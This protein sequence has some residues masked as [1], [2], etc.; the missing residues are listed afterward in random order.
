M[1]EAKPPC[2]YGSQ[3]YRKNPDHLNRY[4]HPMALEEDG[5]AD[6]SD[7]ASAVARDPGEHAPLPIRTKRVNKAFVVF[8]FTFPSIIIIINIWYNRG[9]TRITVAVQILTQRKPN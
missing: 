6:D 2:K 4:Y 3:C 8:F 1:A 9:E 7:S 5:A